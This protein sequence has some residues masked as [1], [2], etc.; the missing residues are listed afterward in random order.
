MATAPTWAQVAQKKKPPPFLPTVCAVDLEQFAAPQRLPTSSSRYSVFIPLP[1]GYKQGWVLDITTNIPPSAVGLVPR[2][3]VSLIEVCFANK[4]AQQL[5]LSSLFVC[6]HFMVQPV[7]PAGTPSIFVPIKLMNVPVL[8]SLVV[9][10]QLRKLWSA[11]GEVVAIA[12]HTYKDL[13]LQPNRW[14]MVLKVKAGSPLSATPFFDLLGFKVMASWPG[15]EKACPRCKTVGHD[16]HSCPKRPAP[17][18]LKKRSPSTTK[19]TTPAP[20]TPSSSTVAITADTADKATPTSD[21]TD[22]ASMDTSSDSLFPFELT[23]EQVQDLNKLTADEWLQHCQN[24]HANAPRTQPEIDQFLS[25]PIARIVEIFRAEVHRLASSSL[26][27]TS[28]TTSDPSPPLPISTPS[29]PLPRCP[30]N[31]SDEQLDQYARYSDDQFR[32]K[33]E[34]LKK[35]Q[36]NRNSKVKAFLELPTDTVAASIKWAVFLK[37]PPL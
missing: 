27:S 2:A 33:A 34:S 4:E 8:A 12:Q 32:D 31:M 29:S 35:N 9:E 14:D 5:F 7:P 30:L 16:S 1:S 24:V 10:Q 13:P 25:L 18:K 23:N 3:D 20:T 17:K 6:K 19:R 11:H 28:A 37:R 22:D 21:P 15:S 26:P 36:K